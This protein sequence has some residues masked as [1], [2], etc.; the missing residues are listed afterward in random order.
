MRKEKTHSLW[1]I[2]Q[3]KLFT[4]YFYLNYITTQAYSSLEKRKKEKK[5]NNNNNNPSS[6]SVHTD[7][8]NYFLDKV[9]KICK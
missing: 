5:K 4:I 1:E 9:K 3:S 7:L 2:T 8:P 6:L